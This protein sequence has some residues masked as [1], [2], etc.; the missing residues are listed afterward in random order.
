MTMTLLQLLIELVII[1]SIIS[2]NL[3]ALS[4]TF[5]IN[6]LSNAMHCMGQN[7]KSLAACVCV[8]VCV[9]ARTGFG[10][11]YLENG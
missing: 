1:S 5:F 10:A 11:Q 3:F 4:F 9:R 7:I 8:S 6:C 2:A